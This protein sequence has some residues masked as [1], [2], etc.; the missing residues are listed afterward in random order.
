MAESRESFESKV[1]KEIEKSGLPTEIK[2]T[3]A[4]NNEGWAVYNEYPYLD[5]D[6]NKI[7]AL[8]IVANRAFMRTNSQEE[9]NDSDCS[10]YIE[11]KKSD[12]H[13]WVFFTQTAPAPFR[14]FS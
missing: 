5:N 6:E 4:L 8:D 1:K 2:A 7:R 14:R 3:N 13:S 11:C 10:L 9:Q 12:K